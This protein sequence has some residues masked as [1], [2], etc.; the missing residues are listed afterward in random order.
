MPEAYSGPTRGT[1][2]E[3]IRTVSCRMLRALAVLLL[4]PLAT[5]C[6]LLG[7]GL[8]LDT[9]R[10]EMHGT[11]A[12][13]LTL[14][15]RGL[16]AIE[17]RIEH[18][19][20]WLVASPSRG[21][22][23]GFGSIRVVLGVDRAF[24]TTESGVRLERSPGTYHTTL[25]A[26]ASGADALASVTFV[27]AGEP[28]A[29]ACTRSSGESS[30]GDP[31]AAMDGGRGAGAGSFRSSTAGFEDA[32]Y[33]RGAWGGDA[34]WIAPAEPTHLLVKLATP[35]DAGAP[36]HDAALADAAATDEATS[37]TAAAVAASHGL[38]DRQRG[39]G[40]GVVL[41]RVPEGTDPAVLAARLE[42]DPRVEYAEPDRPLYPQQIGAILPND[43]QLAQQWAPCR[44]G[45]PA[46]WSVTTGGTPGRST[47]PA[48][49][50]PRSTIAVI[51]S[52][53]DLDHPDLA[54]RLLPGYDFCPVPN[55]AGPSTCTAATP[56]PGGGSSGD[57]HGTHVAGI[58]AGI[59]DNGEGVAG[60][61]WGGAHIVPIKVFD[62][63][64]SVTSEATVA[65]AIY[66]AIGS[67][68]PDEICGAEPNDHPAA[69]LNL[70]L[71]GPG[72]SSTLAAAIAAATAQGALVF[73]ATG[74]GGSL[75]AYQGI[76][77]PANAPDAIAVG[78]VNSNFER[79]HFSRFDVYGGPTTEL[80]APGG[81]LIGTGAPIFS[82]MPDD[83]YGYLSGTSMATPYAAGVAAL[84]WAD[85]PAATATEVWARMRNSAYLAPGWTAAEYGAGVLCVDAALGLATRCGIAD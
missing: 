83:T 14:T 82:A 58:A 81:F 36:P 8:A 38:F 4:V 33:V 45:L 65:C 69:I 31:A 59:G 23:D 47:L 39:P 80:M 6:S 53:V 37:D 20:G 27:V 24:R 13:M 11:S 25:R 43:P 42:A 76:F 28:T 46:A 21:T 10:I 26:V 22:L 78:S 55:A 71:G 63:S 9:N 74:N 62:D 17:W 79:S 57:P 34:P 48:S 75:G 60:V 44:F 73:A 64:G 7:G 50:T 29:D 12:A 66:W 41:V 72:A 77:M 2:R 40:S 49:S 19:A 54:A 67:T 52:G 15:N 51:D 30:A 70:S 5:G 61:A 35:A 84:L 3:P 18:D 68:D 1:A 85:D 56:S 16:G 32:G